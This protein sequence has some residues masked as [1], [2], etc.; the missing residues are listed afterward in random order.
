VSFQFKEQITNLF[1]IAKPALELFNKRL[2][3]TANRGVKVTIAPLTVLATSHGRLEIARLHAA[4]EKMG[5]RGFPYTY[6]HHEAVNHTVTFPVLKARAHDKFSTAYIFFFKL[7]FLLFAKAVKYVEHTA[8]GEIALKLTNPVLRIVFIINSILCIIFGEENFTSTV[9]YFTALPNRIFNYIECLIWK[10]VYLP[11]RAR[12]KKMQ[13][14]SPFFAFVCR[15]IFYFFALMVLGISIILGFLSMYALNEVSLELVI[16]EQR[17]GAFFITVEKAGDPGDNSGEDTT[18]TYGCDD[19][20]SILKFMD[21]EDCTEILRSINCIDSVDGVIIEGSDADVEDNIEEH[22]AL[23]DWEEEWEWA[24]VGRTILEEKVV[25]TKQNEI[26]VAEAEAEADTKLGMDDADCDAEGKSIGNTTN[27]DHEEVEQT[28]DVAGGV[29]E[30]EI[31]LVDAQDS[32]RHVC[33]TVPRPSANDTIFDSEHLSLDCGENIADVDIN[34]VFSFSNN[35]FENA[36][37]RDEE[38]VEGVELSRL[39]D[40]DILFQ[41]DEIVEASNCVT[42]EM[43]RFRRFRFHGGDT[44]PPIDYIVA[45]NIIATTVDHSIDDIT[46]NANDE[47]FGNHTM[48][49]GKHEMNVS[50]YLTPCFLRI[51]SSNHFLYNRHSP[52]Q[53]KSHLSLP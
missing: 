19:R 34:Q 5:C 36:I 29:H 45:D 16:H 37:A 32:L 15:V 42:E 7:L 22:D 4:V 49:S 52:V 35:F 24:E 26:E 8:V 17:S 1:V 39:I 43:H 21:A 51:I 27:T 31:C 50:H 18:I 14:V 30:E 40:K 6:G 20:N 23:V 25:W 3:V 13:K 2:N 53:L 12:F 10:R 9:S 46:V 47:D 41:E 48:S 44:T 11:C 28:M 38:K 33:G